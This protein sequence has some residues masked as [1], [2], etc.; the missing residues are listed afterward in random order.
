MLQPSAE[1]VER[2]LLRYSARKR[3]LRLLAIGDVVLDA[4]RVE[5]APL[6][7]AH[8][9]RSNS[10]PEVS[11]VF[12]PEALFDPVSVDLAGDLAHELRVIALDVLRMSFFEDRTSKQLRGI[13]HQP[14]EP[15]I[16]AQE[17]AFGIYFDDAYACMFVGRREPLVVLPQHFLAARAV[18]HVHG[19]RPRTDQLSVGQ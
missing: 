18:G 2:L 9:R 17:P 3:L 14:S 11:A 10:G 15:R 7:I 1:F 13:S 8:A 16:D 12:A 19:Y 4:N 5:E 6:H